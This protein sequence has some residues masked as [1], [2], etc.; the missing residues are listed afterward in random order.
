M[1]SFSPVEDRGLFLTNNKI[2][3]MH[4]QIRIN[5]KWLLS[6]TIV[7]EWMRITRNGNTLSMFMKYCR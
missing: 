2:S 3:P 7:T 6:S 5:T 1:R 4:F